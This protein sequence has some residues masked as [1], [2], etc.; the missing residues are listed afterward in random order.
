MLSIKTVCIFLIIYL[1]QNC[2]N[3]TLSRVVSD[4][5]STE[6]KF[7]YSLEQVVVT[8]GRME[9]K[10]IHTP[11][12]I[13]VLDKIKL[14]SVNGSR[15]ADALSMAYPL[16]IKSYG[17]VP[18]LNMPGMNG[19]GS[20]HTL[21]IL[22][23]IKMN[24]AQNSVFD[25]S[26]LPLESV[27]RIEIQGNGAGSLYGSDAM[28]GVI[29]VFTE[30][31]GIPTNDNFLNV[32]F[33][34]SRT[35]YRTEKHLLKL[36]KGFKGISAGMFFN[37]ENG[38]GNYEYYFNDGTGNILKERSNSSFSNFDFGLTLQFFPDSL[39]RFRLFSIYISQ[40]KELPGHET[41]IPSPISG[42]IDKNWN[43]ILS[44]YRLF[45]S[46]VSLNAS[47]GFQNNLQRYW[48][49]PLTNSVYKNLATSFQTHLR[50]DFNDIKLSAGYEFMNA[51]TESRELA[52]LVNRNVHS[53]FFS[54]EVNISDFIRFF[55]SLRF[56]NYSDLSKEVI[57]GRLGV[58]IRPVKSLNLHVRANI[59]TNFR[60]PT[61]NDLYWKDSGNRD[62]NPEKSTN[63]EVGA[64][65][66]FPW[67]LNLTLE[68]GYTY[69]NSVDKIVWT[70]KTA[71]IWTP[72]NI[73]TSYSKVAFANITTQ[74]SFNEIFVSLSGGVTFTE[75]RK[76]SRDFP[77][78]PSFDKYIFY[79]PRQSI[80]AS[81]Q[82]IWNS[83]GLN[84]F[85]THSGMRFADME[86]KIT[87]PPHNILDANI[88][89]K[90]SLYKIGGE[91]RLE[92]NNIT[93][94]DFQVISG[95]P[96]PLRNYLIKFSLNY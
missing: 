5:D 72:K 51:K 86:N 87:L 64:I 26:L 68:G 13:E 65:L 71:F 80:K 77:T 93:N 22:D 27:E 39:S 95:Y 55:P 19:M 21:V 96:M 20:E 57:T 94:S 36:S 66:I 30:Y 56:D 14:S 74:K 11:S 48:I 79:V 18:A 67:F 24:S 46:S 47:L 89:W 69:I 43:S 62:L 73:S 23:G 25:L 2:A 17:I 31:N 78:D 92:A 32:N 10:V 8:A 34:S 9:T 75:A 84:F 16:V 49:R 42:Q 33:S 60:A 83:Y 91:I 40:E 1:L 7:N 29:S 28:A 54:S 70:P 82:F 41:G 38:R 88:F 90:F 4:P 61:F 58:N 15:L 76:T 53:A 50:A 52:S 12:R 59:G 6:Y 85:Y 3:A 63:S 35:S 37:R 81:A 45:S 44:Y